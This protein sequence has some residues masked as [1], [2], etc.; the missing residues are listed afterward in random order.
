MN[1]NIS[2]K[3]IWNEIQKV[4]LKNVMYAH[5]T[6]E[7]KVDTVDTQPKFKRTLS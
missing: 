4:F 3:L 6:T 7:N 2:L 5:Q 1:T